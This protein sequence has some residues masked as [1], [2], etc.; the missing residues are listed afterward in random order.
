ML[1]Q[2]WRSFLHLGA[3][4]EASGRSVKSIN[5]IRFFKQHRSAECESRCGKESRIWQIGLQP[6][7]KTCAVKE[8]VDSCFG[9]V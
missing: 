1:A 8:Y 5:E 9:G 6:H 3:G 4:K 7:D 2:I